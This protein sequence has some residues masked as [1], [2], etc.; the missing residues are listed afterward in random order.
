MYLRWQRSLPRWVRLVPVELPGRGMRMSEAFID[1]F[2]DL[3]ELLC[4]EHE[5]HCNGRYALYGH[6]MGGLIAYGMV[7]RWRAQ[8]RRLP[9]V[10]FAS[11]SPAPKHRD[12]GYFA[13]KETDAAL[14]ADLR[15]QGGT[16]DEVFENS[17]MQR[18]TLDTL[19]A[20]YRICSGYQHR[21]TQ[22]LAAPI[23]VFAGRQ[24]DIEAEHIFAWETETFARFSVRWFDGGHFFIRPHESTVLG[25]V[26]RHLSDA[27]SEVAHAPAVSA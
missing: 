4:E 5:R 20:D 14:I 8:S 12:P 11:A 1:N 21:D 18:I 19:R 16:P 10:F 9:D 23:H 24:D 2:D 26:V 6:S 27:T 25:A 13:N 15:K 7:M 17:E 22:P 3:V